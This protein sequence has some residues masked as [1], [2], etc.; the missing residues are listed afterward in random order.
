MAVLDIVK[1]PDPRLR[2]ATFDVGE[3]TD[4]IRQLVRDLIDTMYSLNAAGI[5]AIQVGRLERVFVLDGKVPAGGDDNS[6]RSSSSTPSWSSPA[7]ASRSPKRA[8]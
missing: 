2:E 4:D 8:A 7:R 3:I 6:P 1:Y 5:A